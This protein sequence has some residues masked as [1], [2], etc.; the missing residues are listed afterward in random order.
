MSRVTKRLGTKNRQAR[1]DA[2]VKYY[3]NFRNGNN[4]F[5]K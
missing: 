4:R 1:K 5:N 3:R 2:V